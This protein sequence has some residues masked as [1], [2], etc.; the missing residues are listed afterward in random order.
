MKKMRL[1]PPILAVIYLALALA[2]SFLFPQLSL[3][4]APLHYFG[5]PV[6]LGGVSLML[7]A[8][9]EFK[10]KG[11]THNPYN[12]PTSLVTSGPFAF[13]RNPMYLGLTVMLL[14][15]SIFAAAIPLYLVPFAF[16][17]T[18]N[19][20]FVPNE[21]RKLKNIFGKQYEDY[22]KQVNRWL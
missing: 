6:L 7:W 10:G 11:T 5:V 16:L 2:I 8:R 22:K 18:M 15:I 4:Y 1:Y 14:G 20:T 21:E 19:A 3:A 9:Q 13:T 17:L 12:E